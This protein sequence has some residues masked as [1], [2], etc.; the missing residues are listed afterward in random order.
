MKSI[1]SRF[2]KNVWYNWVFAACVFLYLI[3]LSLSWFY[4][5]GKL[6]QVT[7]SDVSKM[8]GREITV[9]DIRFNPFKLSLTVK[10]LSVSDPSGEPLAEWDSLLVNFSLLRSVFSWGLAYSEIRLDNPHFNIVKLKKGFNFSDIIE[11]L[12]SFS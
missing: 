10:D 9:G 5:P 8:I 7:E 11:R 12:S 3:Y 1:A 2:K 4:L 6:K